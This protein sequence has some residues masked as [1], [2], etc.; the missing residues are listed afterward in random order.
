MAR[1]G[2]L[3]AFA[4]SSRR[5]HELSGLVCQI[6]QGLGFG[7]S[8][9]PRNRKLVMVGGAKDCRYKSHNTFGRY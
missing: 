5:H 6:L 4:S 7:L 1:K 9:G 3:Y 8:F 2:R